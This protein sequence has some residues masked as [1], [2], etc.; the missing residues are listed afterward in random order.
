MSSILLKSP[1]KLFK[2]SPNGSGSRKSTGR[3]GGSH[4]KNLS[5]SNFG[6][7]SQMTPT[8]NQFNIDL[9]FEDKIE[10]RGGFQRGATMKLTPRDGMDS[11]RGSMVKRQ[12]DN[13]SVLSRTSN[14]S[15][16]NSMREQRVEEEEKDSL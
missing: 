14:G 1:V 11:L 12:N 13:G 2:G 7:D 9:N 5:G 16:Q 4:M 8:C 10:A 3:H 6:A 15:K